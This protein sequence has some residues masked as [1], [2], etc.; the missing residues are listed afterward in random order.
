MIKKQRLTTGDVSDHLEC[1]VLIATTAKRET[2][3]TL[4]SEDTR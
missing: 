4:L 3:K 1:D 2:F